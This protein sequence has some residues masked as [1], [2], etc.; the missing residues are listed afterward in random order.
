MSTRY[1]LFWLGSSKLK[2]I[3]PLHPVPGH[4]IVLRTTTPPLHRWLELARPTSMSP[5]QWSQYFNAYLPLR[6]PLEPDAAMLAAPAAAATSTSTST[7]D[8]VPVVNNGEPSLFPLTAAPIPNVYSTFYGTDI[9][10]QA[11]ACD[12]TTS[13]MHQPAAGDGYYALQSSVFTT[14]PSTSTTYNMVGDYG[15]PQLG[16]WDRVAAQAHY[17]SNAR[18]HPRPPPRIKR[19]SS[20]ST[21]TSSSVSSSGSSSR[22]VVKRSRM[23]CLTCRLRKKRCCETRPRCA[24]CSRLGLLCVWPKPGTEYKNRPKDQKEDE[25]TINHEIYGKIKVLRGIIEHKT[26]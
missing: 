13:P 6:Q 9:A 4:L 18:E 26:R 21:S 8:R 12:S 11:P 3:L 20:E 25:K 10:G 1:F 15:Q 14:Q 17:N 24:E 5:N 7:D 23:G 22:P 19:R 2:P 16:Q